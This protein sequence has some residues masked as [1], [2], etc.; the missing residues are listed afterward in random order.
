MSANAYLGARPVVEAL[1]QGAQIV[2][3]GRVTDTALALAPMIHEF[4]W[5]VERLG[6]A[7]RR[8]HRRPHHRVR[9]P[10]HGRQLQPLVGGAGP[11]ERRLSDRRGA[12]GRHLR[13]HQARGDR[14]H[15]DGRHGRR[16]ARL[17]DGRPDGVHHAGRDRR[18]HLDPPAPGRQGPGGGLGHPG[19][20]ATRR[21]SRS[22][23][24]TSP[25]TRRRGQITVSGPRAVEKAQL[26]A[27]IVW[28]RLERA[29]V[30]FAPE[31]RETEL[32]GTGACL[33]GILAGAGRSA[34]GGPAARRARRRLA[35]RSSASAR[36]SRRWSPPV[37]RG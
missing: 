4:G 9:R 13:G 1:G 15:G 10:V 31:D 5:G 23:A 2:L 12:R 33:P 35:P 8:H 18:L 24:R 25:A 22:R 19:E 32:V 34:G 36:R 11:L 6:P 29:G 27:E 16:A 3:C 14:R 7:R 20:A 28:K 37:R 21:S 26:A 17:R 30:T